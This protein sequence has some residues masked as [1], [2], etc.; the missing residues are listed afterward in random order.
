MI[1]SLERLIDRIV[2][3]LFSGHGQLS[4]H[5]FMS[6]SKDRVPSGKDN[7]TSFYVVEDICRGSKNVVSI[8][9]VPVGGRL[10]VYPPQ[11]LA[12][13]PVDFIRRGDSEWSC[14][15]VQ[16]RILREL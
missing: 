3:Y 7:D 2:P 12:G 1:A 13:D 10:R 8:N 9:L 14:C 4:I 16:K 5:L 6:A 11:N 15:H